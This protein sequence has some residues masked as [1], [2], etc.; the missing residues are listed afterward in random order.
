MIEF[1]GRIVGK[2]LY[3][4]ILLDYSFSYVFVQKL[5]GRYSFLDELSTLD[6]ELYKNL[7][8]VKVIPRDISIHAVAS[9]VNPL[10][11]LIRVIHNVSCCFSY[12]SLY[13][14]FYMV[15][16]C[17]L[18]YN[19]PPSLDNLVPCAVLLNYKYSCIIVYEFSRRANVL[20]GGCWMLYNS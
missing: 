20:V 4:G 12:K 7:M 5:L 3:E 14:K 2:A 1:L 13:L 11:K 10:L 6:P 19:V 18:A 16:C 17:F 8:Y 15:W 9:L